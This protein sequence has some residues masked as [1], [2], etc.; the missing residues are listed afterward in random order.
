MYV[1][2]VQKH[3]VFTYWVHIT[4][5]Q[6]AEKWEKNRTGRENDSNCIPL[7]QQKSGSF[8]IKAA[9]DQDEREVL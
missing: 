3:S 1:I 6:A 5:P 2:T 8:F 4:K 7:M 9:L